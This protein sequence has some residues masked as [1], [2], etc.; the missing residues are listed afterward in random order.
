MLVPLKDIPV[1]VCLNRFV[2]FPILG[3]KYVKVVHFLFLFFP[4]V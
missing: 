2:I 1:L 4:L 3:L